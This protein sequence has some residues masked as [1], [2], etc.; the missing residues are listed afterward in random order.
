MAKWMPKE[1]GF[2]NASLPGELIRAMVITIC[3]EN[4]VI[5][6]LLNAPISKHLPYAKDQAVPVK[7]STDDMGQEIWKA[8]SEAEMALAVD[9]DERLRAERDAERAAIE[10]EE[11]AR[12]PLQHAFVVN[13]T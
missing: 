2:L 10:A 4:V 9:E 1:D 5:V 13:Q 7:R 12:A 11:K 6:Q 3:S 8:I